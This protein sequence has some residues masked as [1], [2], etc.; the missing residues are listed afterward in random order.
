[1]RLFQVEVDEAV[2]HRR[3]QSVGLEDRSARD[4]IVAAGRVDDD[5][6]GDRGKAF[7]RLVELCFAQLLEHF[8]GR[9]GQG[10]VEPAHG[11]VAILEIAGHGALAA[12][13]VERGDAMARCG[14]RDRGVDRGR[15]LAGAALFI[16][17]NDEMRLSHGSP[18][19][20]IF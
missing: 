8:I 15:R 3:D 19:P 12:V 13:E 7:D 18:K 1:V 14:K 11:R 9:V 20:L 10:L 5:H 17:E 4:R 16:G 6:V 2:V